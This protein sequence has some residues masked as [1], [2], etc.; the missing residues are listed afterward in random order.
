VEEQSLKEASLVVEDAWVAA[1]DRAS[2][3]AVYAL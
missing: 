2:V 3:Q 1:V